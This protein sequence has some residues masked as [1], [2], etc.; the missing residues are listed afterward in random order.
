MIR[1]LFLLLIAISPLK[2]KASEARFKDLMNVRGVR[3]NQ[4]IGFGVVVGL[5]GTGDSKKSIA[6][7]RAVANMLTRL[8]MK[9]HASEVVAG[10]V[11]GVVATVELPAFSRIGD[12]L[13]V[14]VSTVGDA[15]SLAGGML[16]M[17]PLRGGDSRVYAMAQGAVVV[18]QANGQK[19]QVLTVAR[20]PGGST[21]EKEFL[22]DIASEGFIT[23]SLKNP[24]FTTASRM[25][26][27]INLYFKG[28]YAQAND[29]ASLKVQVP[30]S[31]QASGKLVDFISELEN[32]KIQADMKAQVV[33]NE[34]TG[35]VVMGSNVVI[36][37]IT[38]THGSLSIQIEDKKSKKSKKGADRKNVVSMGGTTVGELIETMN[39]MGVKP[40]DLVG[41][42][43]SIHAAGALR[44]DVKFL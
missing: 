31:Y 28:F 26:E 39:A 44:A 42:V 29:V 11:A 9:T 10:N 19:A 20:V 2:A 16:L 5:N 30:P 22:P 18:G 41:I 32:L 33:L 40:E 34:R 13:D 8:G 1:F 12:K 23:L 21:V 4:L 17:T 6:T 27:K 36:E 24:D 25:V 35:T 15:K 14:K 38:I 3:T 7:N 37:P 43:Q